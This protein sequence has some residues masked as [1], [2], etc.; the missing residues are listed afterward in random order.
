MPPPQ[1]SRI[2]HLKISEQ[3]I[4]QAASHQEEHRLLD[5]LQSDGKDATGLAEGSSL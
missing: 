3:R 2:R 4:N 1:E 5:H